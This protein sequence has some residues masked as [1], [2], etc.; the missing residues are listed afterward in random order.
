MTL[1]T[2]DLGDVAGGHDPDDHV[3]IRAEAFRESQ[4][5]GIT[6]TA[7]VVIPLVN[8]VGQAEVEPGPVVVSFRCQAVADTREKRGVVPSSGTVGIEDVIAGAFEYTP[9]VVNR[10]LDQIEGARDEALGQVSGAVAAEVDTIK[11]NRGNSTSL[12]ATTA[13]ELPNGLTEIWSS[14]AATQLGLPTNERGV[15]I[16]D[17]F[18]TAGWQMFAAF[19]TSGV[20]TY[21]RSKING[22]WSP[23][24][25]TTP[26]YS[27]LVRQHGN[28]SYLSGVTKADSLPGGWTQVW[29]TVTANDL[30]LP[31]PALGSVLSDIYG[32]TGTQIFFA[33]LPDGLQIWGRSRRS[34]VWAEWALMGGGPPKAPEP[35]APSAGMRVVPL[36]LTMPGGSTSQGQSA[37]AA[38][39]VRQWAHMPK[40]VRL[41]IRN[42]NPANNTDLGP[43][44]VSAKVGPAAADGSMRDA[45][46]LGT[47]SLPASGEYV[48]DWITLPTIT[49]TDHLGVAL[50]FSE[51]TSPQ[52]I[53]QG[54]GWMKHSFADWDQDAA[55]MTGWTY[56]QTLPFYVWVE[57]EVP[58]RAP[59]ILVNGDSI[60]IGTN[61]TTPVSD[62]WPAIHA[63]RQGALPVFMSQ[64]GSTMESWAP[65]S[66]RWDTMY[67]GVDVP[68][69]AI[70]TALGQNDL[71]SADLAT[72]KSRYQAVASVYEDRWPG[73]PV[74]AGA[75]TPSNKPPAVEAV[76][77]QYNA[78]LATNPTGERGFFDFAAAVGT[79][80]GEDLRPEY[81]A[82]L[83]HPN[84][85]G[86]EVMA[87][88]VDAV[89]VVPVCLSDSQ[90]AQIAS[91][92]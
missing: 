81:S 69:D 68:A 91:N 55:P 10:G 56:R 47:V 9:P 78:W 86:Q 72:L 77:R 50:G 18:G 52:A 87:G 15:V 28:I 31:V 43:M 41:H 49:D 89:P 75:V 51:A 4:G 17:Q 8:G 27:G 24:G 70:I 5:G 85:E 71:L 7:E 45:L 23:W 16:S 74:Y 29:S 53:L 80:D 3:V 46:S 90:I 1:V 33:A 14:A 26:D 67:P 34:S 58:A 54:G 73:V 32:N 84:T 61:A 59:V 40:R 64:H 19:L 48:S 66:T 76:R 11:W 60:S 12:P 35:I 44:A 21:E 88:V 57:A 39:I 62:A 13:A 25:K 92:F 63:R 82:D 20:I 36:A 22:V 42:G 2:I 38:R 6:S 37:G 30:G 83:L 65:D 79:T